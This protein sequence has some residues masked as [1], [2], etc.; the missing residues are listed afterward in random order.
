MERQKDL[1][2]TRIAE[3]IDYIV[4]N[5]R[6]Q[7]GLYD[8]AEEVHLSP[9]HFQRLFHEWA[10]LSPKKFLQYISIA[11]AKKLLQENATLLEAAHET[12]L[13]GSSRLHDLFVRIEGMSP[14]DY[15]NGG[16]NLHINYSIAESPFGKLIVASTTKGVCWMAFLEDEVTGVELMKTKFPNASFKQEQDQLQQ[17]ALQIFQNDWTKMPEIKLHLKGTDFQLKVWETL[18]KIPMGQLSTYGSIAQ[19]IDSPKASRAVGT[20]IGSNPIA[21]LIPCHRV[22]QSTGNFGGYMWGYEKNGNHW[23]GMCKN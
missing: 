17:S 19:Q 3:A 8:I 23:L 22:I 5:F 14:A 13:S 18:L 7:P 6:K 4:N 15:K 1:N 12:G 20:A 16:K 21:F 9:F 11:H 10:G 2:Y